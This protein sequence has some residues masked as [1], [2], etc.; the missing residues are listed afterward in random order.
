M[1][2][3]CDYRVS[4][5]VLQREFEIMSDAKP[6]AGI[7]FEDFRR[8]ASDDSLSQYQKIGFPDEYRAGL[9]PIIFEDIL[10]KLSNLHQ[11]GLAV[12]DIG[13]GCSDLPNLLTNL[14]R[15][16]RHAL[17]FVDCPEMLRH[18]E[19]APFV[20]KVS[21]LFPNCSDMINDMRG[22][23][24]AVLCYSVLQYALIDTA[25]FRFFDSALGLLAPRGQLLIGD[26]PNV[27]KRKRFLASD[28]GVQFHRT[29]MRTASAPEV[30]FNQL[31]P[32]QIDDA[33][34]FALASRARLAGFDAY[35]MP[36]QPTLPMANRREDLLVIRP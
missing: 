30:T 1:A 26:I 32:D 12:V 23:A 3:R 33:I 11:P 20:R 27:S 16:N 22:K 2:A 35:I 7:G 17:T 19:D 24:N 6:I 28:A 8:L 31:E 10:S 29:F 36:Q 21:A 34:V 4:A 15:Q 5:G 13:P 14:C 9:E 18:L 25:L